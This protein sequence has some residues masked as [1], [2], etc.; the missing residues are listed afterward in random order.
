MRRHPQQ[1]LALAERS[2]HKPQRAVL[3][4]AQAAMDQLRGCRRRARRKIVLLDEH[5]L[6]PA[7][8]GIAGDAGAIDA[9]A[10]DGKIEIGH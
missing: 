10:D 5:D 9:A 3:Q 8:G 1:H 2:A 6:E 4:I 7:P